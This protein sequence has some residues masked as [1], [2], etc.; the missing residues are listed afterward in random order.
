MSNS[1]EYNGWTNYATWRVN[2]EMFD[3]MD[4]NDLFFEDWSSAGDLSD[5]LRVYAREHIEETAS[6]VARDWALA[7]LSDVN[8]HSIAK[9]MIE[10]YPAEDAAE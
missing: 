1:Q 10:A 6:G 5:C 2:L 8:F 9:H 7:F 3:G 4:P